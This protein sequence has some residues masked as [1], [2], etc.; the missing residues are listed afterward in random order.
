MTRRS[1]TPAHL[2]CVPAAPGLDT[3]HGVVTCR[4]VGGEP[5]LSTV[6]GASSAVNGTLMAMAPGGNHARMRQ[7]G[8]LHEASLESALARSGPGQLHG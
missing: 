4:M 7:V 2:P 8:S 5:V 3:L 1:L 6:L